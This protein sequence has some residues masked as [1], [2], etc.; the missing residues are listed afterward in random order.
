MYNNTYRQTIQ[1][2]KT[3]GTKKMSELTY[4][5]I[6]TADERILEIDAILFD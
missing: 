6:D 1:K 4:E 3:K 2:L 5:T